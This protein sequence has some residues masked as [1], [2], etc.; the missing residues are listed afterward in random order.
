MPESSKKTPANA[1]KPVPAKPTAARRQASAQAN[2][3]PRPLPPR[4]PHTQPAPPRQK[5]GL[6]PRQ[7]QKKAAPAAQPEQN[8][9][10]DI[11]ELEDIVSTLQ[12][13]DPEPI[14]DDE[15]LFHFEPS[16]AAPAAP[17]EA[18]FPTDAEQPGPQS[19]VQSPGYERPVERVEFRTSGARFLNDTFAELEPFFTK[20]TLIQAGLGAVVL[21]LVFLAG[22]YVGSPPATPEPEPQTPSVQLQPQV[23]LLSTA[24]VRNLGAK[25][26]DFGPT[27]LAN[28]MIR[29]IVEQAG[30]DV[31]V[32]KFSR[33]DE[34]SLL[35]VDFPNEAIVLTEGVKGSGMILTWKGFVLERLRAAAQGQNFEVTPQGE[36]P[37][38]LQRF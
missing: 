24:A 9:S 37:A 29:F 18:A 5:P 28:V 1:Q 36:S 4:K 12:T 31:Y 23:E 19:A 11:L 2:Y 25:P 3:P 8:P 21:M 15:P 35:T 30:R 26:P 33:G 34:P 27:E 38:S 10:Q 6:P 32:L 17:D 14:H 20:T 7:P 22:V 13:Q 16:S